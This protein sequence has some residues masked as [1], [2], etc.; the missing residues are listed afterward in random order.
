MKQKTIYNP[1]IHHRRSI[2][3]QGYDYSQAG[4]YFI[5]ICCQNRACLFGE[6]RVAK[7]EYFQPVHVPGVENIL[8]HAGAEY[9]QP[10]MIL[11]E[12]GKV[13][14]KCWLDIPKHFPNAILHE[15]I[16]M[17]NHVH[18]IVEIGAEY[19]QPIQGEEKVPYLPQQQNKFQQMIPRSI[20]SIVK[21][22]KIGVTKWMRQNTDVYDVWQRNYYENIIRD[23][24][25]YFNISNYIIN[26]PAKWAADKFYL[27]G[28][29]NHD[30]VV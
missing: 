9:F 17:P 20:G 25:S 3:L 5:T 6:I 1:N 4:L 10:R 13:A 7:A 21:G 15:H 16:I 18:G 19:L 24:K 26:N 28:R 8:G 23:E 2:R 11:N 27:D 29:N 22:F 14:D 30:H 12:A